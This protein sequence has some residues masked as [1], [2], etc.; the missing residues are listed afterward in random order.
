MSFRKDELV[1]ADESD[2]FDEA[3]ENEGSKP[4][5]E[6]GI[7]GVEDAY[8][9][10]ENIEAKMQKISQVIRGIDKRMSYNLRLMGSVIMDNNLSNVLPE[11]M[12]APQ[13]NTPNQYLG[14]ASPNSNANE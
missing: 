2:D 12:I 14:E 3:E 10:V 4:Q 13:T 5:K 8:E 9:I 1:L 6:K 7:Q 11:Q